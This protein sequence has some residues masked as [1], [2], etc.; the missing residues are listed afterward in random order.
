MRLLLFLSYNDLETYLRQQWAGM[1]FNFLSQQSESKRV[2]NLLETLTTMNER[3]EF[4]AKQILQIVGTNKN[5]ARSEINEKMQRN[6]LIRTLKCYN[7]EINPEDII[8]N[9]E[10]SSLL[11]NL[12]IQVKEKENDKNVTLILKSINGVI[13]ELKPTKGAFVGFI[14]DYES[15]R[16]D[17]LM[18]LK[19]FQIDPAG[20]LT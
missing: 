6:E 4:V 11:D 14:Q 3:I 7:F 8:R 1:M 13:T 18:V 10:L 12:K 19:R 17:S 9:Y 2:A 16:H 15:L 5:R 20:F